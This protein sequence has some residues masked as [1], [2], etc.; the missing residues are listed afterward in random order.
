MD[1]LGLVALVALVVTTARTR[2]G[3]PP[4]AGVAAWKLDN[5]NILYTNQDISYECPINTMCRCASLPNETALLEI[6]CNEVSLYKFPGEF[7]MGFL[8]ECL[9]MG[10]IIS[11][12]WPG[13]RKRFLSKNPHWNFPS[14]SEIFYFVFFCS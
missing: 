1:R 4:L 11:W 10:R 6:N 7:M 9:L 2:L 5:R 3:W 8:K 14:F 12:P 13:I